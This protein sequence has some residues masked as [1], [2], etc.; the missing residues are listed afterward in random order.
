MGCSHTGL[1]SV[2][3]TNRKV[4]TT[5]GRFQIKFGMTTNFEQQQTTN[6]L[7]TLQHKRKNI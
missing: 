3:P 1:D 6:N 2:S 4:L 5:K 7:K